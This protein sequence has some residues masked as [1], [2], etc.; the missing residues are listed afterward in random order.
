MFHR[1]VALYRNAYA[2]LSAPVWWMSLVMLVNR[3]GTMVL[4]F[5]TVYLTAQLGFTISE[6]GFVMGMFGLGSILGAFAGGR[7]TDKIGFYSIQFWS[8]LLNGILFIVLGQMHTLWQF[9][10][11]IF[12]LSSIGEAFRPA[13]AAAIAFY[14][15]PENRTRSYSLNRLAIN[16]GWSIGPAVGGILAGFSYQ[17]LFWVDGFTCMFAAILLRICLPPVKEKITKEK[18]IKI[19]DPASSAY[20]DKIYLKFM[21]LVFL[22]ALCFL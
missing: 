12:V 10:I 3:A 2:G 6:A 15:K 5:L 22:V 16:L 11:C 8:L 9:G 17:L 19:A 14:S 21:L 1:S 13:N 18:E 4:P 20:R 7:L